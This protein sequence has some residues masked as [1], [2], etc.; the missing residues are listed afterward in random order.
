LRKKWK[1]TFKILVLR[2]SEVSSSSC[3]KTESRDAEQGS[4]NGRTE[5][6]TEYRR[7]TKCF[8]TYNKIKR[9]THSG[10]CFG[11]KPY[12][13]STSLVKMTRRIV[14]QLIRAFALY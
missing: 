9:P 3:K 1:C 10:I 12:H 8:E 11:E 14:Q 13:V 6:G 2:Q 7:L 4:S 5:G